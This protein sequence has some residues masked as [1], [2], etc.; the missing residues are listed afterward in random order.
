ML[1]FMTAPKA[2]PAIPQ[3]AANGTRPRSWLMRASPAPNRPTP[4]QADH[5][6]RRPRALAEEQVGGQRGDGADHEPGRAAERVARDQHDVGRRLDVGQRRERDPPERGHRR[7]RG[8]ERDHARRR[9][10]ALVPDEAHDE[11]GAEDERGGGDPA[12]GASSPRAAGGPALRRV[13]PATCGL[14]PNRRRALLGVSAP[15]APPST[16]ATWVAKYQPP[17]STACGSASAT[18]RPSPSRITRVAKAA[19]NSASWVA[20]MHVR[21]SSAPRAR[22]GAPGP[23]RAWARR[24]AGAR[25]RRRARAAAPSAAARRRTRRAGGGRR[26]R[27]RARR[28]RSSR[29][30]DGRRDA[31]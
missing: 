7:Q 12:H 20:T 9:V 11:H 18:G 15:P 25:R 4:P 30:S 1:R 5:L 22:R 14:W 28:R 19:A 23:S 27:S 16:R 26:A 31:G 13:L 6:P 21:S 29:A 24:A 17:A 8:H 3:A 10:G 2:R